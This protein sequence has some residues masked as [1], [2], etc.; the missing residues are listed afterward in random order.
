[1]S[2]QLIP[3]K[4][5][6]FD[7]VSDLVVTN[8][9]ANATKWEIPQTEVTSLSDSHTA[10]HKAFEKTRDP[11]TRTEGTVAAKNTARDAHE[12][13]MRKFLKRWIMPNDAV[14]DEARRNMKLPI[15]KKTRVRVPPPDDV[16]EPEGKATTIDGRISI[17]WRGRK[18]GSK[19]NP[20]YQK[21]IVRHIVLPL[22]APAPTHIDQLTHSLLDGR[23][24]CELSFPEEDWGKVVYFATAYQN[25]RG[26]LGDWSPIGSVIIPGRKV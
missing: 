13:H 2:T 16:P 17:G 15:Y 21:V 18:S 11:A 22:D 7:Q 25:E 1:M 5:V 20:Y 9:T 10:W 23:Q 4:D 3:H 26:E 24:P 6:D 12:P 19:A 8:T 14:S